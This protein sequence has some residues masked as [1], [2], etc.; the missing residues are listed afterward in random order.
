LNFVLVGVAKDPLMGLV[1]EQGNCYERGEIRN[2]HFA[3]VSLSFS[4]SQNINKHAQLTHC[5]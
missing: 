5:P 2:P 1:Q 3:T 4:H